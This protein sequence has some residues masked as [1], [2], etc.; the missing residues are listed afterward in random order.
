MEIRKKKPSDEVV[1]SGNFSESRYSINVER[2]L[3]FRG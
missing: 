2:R 1:N 3:G